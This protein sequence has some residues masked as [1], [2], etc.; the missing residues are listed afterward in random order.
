MSNLDPSNKHWLFDN[1][2]RTNFVISINNSANL[3]GNGFL[4]KNLEDIVDVHSRRTDV[5]SDESPPYLPAEPGDEPT[6]Q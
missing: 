6:N 5:E 1:H 2:K 3:N 4:P